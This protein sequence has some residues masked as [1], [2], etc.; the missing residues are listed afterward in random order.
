MNLCKTEDGMTKVRYK[1]SNRLGLTNNFIEYDANSRI[2][3]SY[4]EDI[5]NESED[6]LDDEES[7]KDMGRDEAEKI[8]MGTDS[9]YMNPWDAAAVTMREL[10]G[11]QKGKEGKAYRNKLREAYKSADTSSELKKAVESLISTAAEE[12]QGLMDRINKLFKEQNKC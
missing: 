1:K 2:E 10:E 3:T 11:P 5:R 6:D 8:D 9:E 7:A 4:F 12:K